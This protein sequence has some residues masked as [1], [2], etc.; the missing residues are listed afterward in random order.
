MLGVPHYTAF[1]CELDRADSVTR[2]GHFLRLR[3]QRLFVG[4]SMTQTILPSVGLQR[5]RYG[6]MTGS[7]L[8]ASASWF[9]G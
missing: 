8:A 9:T 4:A 5:L 2:D 1:P 6:L 7:L 3:R